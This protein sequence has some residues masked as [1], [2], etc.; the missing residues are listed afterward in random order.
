MIKRIRSSGHRP[1]YYYFKTWESIETK[2]SHI[3]TSVYDIRSR[4]PR[5]SPELFLHGLHIGYNP[6]K[7]HVNTVYEHGYNI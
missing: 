3:G 1:L 4:F 5:R 2:V 7:A 6:Y